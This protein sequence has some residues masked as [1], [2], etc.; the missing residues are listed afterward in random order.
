MEVEGD[1]TKAEMSCP[2]PQNKLQEQLPE[3][4]VQVNVLLFESCAFPEVLW[5]VKAAQDVVFGR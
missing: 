5:H 3:P 2:S 4:F 1:V